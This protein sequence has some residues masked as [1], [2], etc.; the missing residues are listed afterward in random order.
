MKK[1][2]SYAIAVAS[3]LAITAYATIPAGATQQ[4][5]C[6]AKV[7]YSVDVAN[8]QDI[9][10]VLGST[11]LNS[12]LEKYGCGID[13]DQIITTP[14]TTPPTEA[15]TTPDNEDNSG[16]QG[17][18]EPLPPTEAPT[19]PP[20]TPPTEAPTTPDNED[21]SGNQ[22][23][24]EPLPPTEAPTTPPTTPPTEAPTT[25]DTEN[26]SNISEYERE[27]ADLVN[28][29]RAENG[30]S[31]LTLNAELSNVA[32]IKSQDMKDNNYFSH[33]SPT[34]GS[35]FDMMKSFG[36]N[37]NTAGENIARGQHTPQAVVD[38]WMNS[39]GHR[40]NILNSSFTEIG[41]GYVADGNYWTQMFI[42]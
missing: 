10:S 37:Y 1:K 16:N 24:D 38:A 4:I 7:C 35:P 40:A 36:I 27:V 29:I 6:N 13:F 28:E 25:P 9:C 42:G 2:S 26:N 32:R 22:G 41:V 21:N 11:D 31:L 23:T 30:L 33:T 12:L 39:E 19:T 17:T 34:Y 20:T 15:P 18:D 5:D 3:I 8:A 14:P